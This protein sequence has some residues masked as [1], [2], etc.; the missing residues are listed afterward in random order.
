MEYRVPEEVV[1]FSAVAP[2]WAEE[3]M[4]A[5]LVKDAIAKGADPI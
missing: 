1:P 2:A 3:A 5:E 4:V